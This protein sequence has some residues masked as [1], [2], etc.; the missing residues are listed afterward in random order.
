M[1]KRRELLVMSVM[2]MLFTL[3]MGI[4]A[5]A[6]E[7]AAISPFVIKDYEIPN[8]MSVA[9]HQ[10]QLDAGKDM[11]SIPVNISTAGNVMI[12]INHQSEGVKLTVSLSKSSDINDSN[13]LLGKK[14]VS[15]SGRFEI[16]TA[17]AEK[18][19][20][21]YLHILGDSTYR[22]QDIAIKIRAVQVESEIIKP[23][24]V[25]LSKTSVIWNGKAQKPSVIAKDSSGLKIDSSL[26]TVKYSNNKNVGQATAIIT[27]KTLYAGTVKKTF[28]IVPKGTALS[29]VTPIS[30]GF[31]IKWKKQAKQA[32]GYEIQ[33]SASSKFK[34]AKT[35]KNIKTK[36]TSKKVAKLEAGKKYYVR[37][38]T[39]K[40]AKVNG[41]AKKLYSG[42]SKAK[43]II[44][45]E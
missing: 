34:G 22:N 14:E 37:I 42:W 38:R 31:Y 21:W 3:F 5:M 39:Y 29:G 7:N 15:A 25:R 41:K 10:Y 12:G 19:C 13:S 23:S 1:K 24:N 45:E 40:T 32:D 33:Y 43:S 18:A 35:L 20:T 36:A 17:D 44:T 28:T 26:Y 16:F 27:F 6:A 11:M 2:A 30:K 8:D 9:E 4:N